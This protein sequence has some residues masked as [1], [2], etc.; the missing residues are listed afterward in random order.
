MSATS[1]ASSFVNVEDE[2]EDDLAQLE[3]QQEALAAQLAALQAD[4]ACPTAAAP[5]TDLASDLAA[6]NAKLRAQLAA[7]ESASAY[8]S[9]T[10]RNSELAKQQAELDKLAAENAKLSEA[11]ATGVGF[12]KIS[13]LRPGASSAVA[14]SHARSLALVSTRSEIC[15]GILPILCA[16]CQE[17]FQVHW[18]LSSCRSNTS[19]FL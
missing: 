19:H 3:A 18:V 16:A 9:T 10:R 13:T 15:C 5:R 12:S 7:L 6:D 11:L 2:D 17:L 4:P 1:S 14:A 8:K